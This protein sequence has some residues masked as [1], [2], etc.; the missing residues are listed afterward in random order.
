MPKKTPFARVA[1]TIPA[2][3]LAAAD[4]VAR[5][6]SR[7]RSWVIAEAVRRYAATV[8]GLPPHPVGF[9]VNP[10]SGLGPSRVAQ[11]IAD[12]ELTP[13]AR[14]RAA[15]ETARVSFNLR[16]SLG[17]RVLGFDRYE[18]YLEWKRREGRGG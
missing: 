1:I 12:L 14:V 16:P 2:D 10:E 11:L 5:Q 8:A 4:R 13:E 3:D 18:E 6:Q 9:E 17:M 15:E 7:S